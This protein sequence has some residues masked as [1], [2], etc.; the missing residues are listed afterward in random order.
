MSLR[1]FS[2]GMSEVVL[3]WVA[4]VCNAPWFLVPNCSQVFIFAAVIEDWV[5]SS[6]INLVRSGIAY[7]FFGVLLKFLCLLFLQSEFC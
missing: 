4:G 2:P 1:S 6:K 3:A 7:D 5:L